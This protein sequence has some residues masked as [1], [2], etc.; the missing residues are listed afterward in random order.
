MN[1]QTVADLFRRKAAT[2]EAEGSIQKHVS[3]LGLEGL[4]DELAADPGFGEVCELLRK[5]GDFDLRVVI[6]QSI[7]PY[8][9]IDFG[10]P[11]QGLLDFLVDACR[12]A[13]SKKRFKLAL[14]SRLPLFL[15]RK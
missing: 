6:E 10:V 9:N 1:P 7:M 5:R 2:W 11:L 4:A 3:D 14:P 15:H 12:E 8:L 13:C